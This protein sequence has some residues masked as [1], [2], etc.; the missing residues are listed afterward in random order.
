MFVR[1][2]DLGKGYGS[3]KALGIYQEDAFKAHIHTY[4]L[5]PFGSVS[6]G[7][8]TAGSRTGESFNTAST[9]TTETRPKNVALLYCM[10][11]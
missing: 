7:G 1:G 5:Y 6:F 9:G 2:L 8:D 3:G 10:K 4:A 11:V